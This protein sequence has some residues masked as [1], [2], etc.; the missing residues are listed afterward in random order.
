MNYGSIVVEE[1]TLTTTTLRWF[2][3]VVVAPIRYGACEGIGVAGAGA[4]AVFGLYYRNL[5]SNLVEA[6]PVFI[7]L[8]ENACNGGTESVEYLEIWRLNYHQ[9]F[10]M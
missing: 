9:L 2:V 8:P 1:L 4:F 10:G 5:S 7:R 6:G 3:V